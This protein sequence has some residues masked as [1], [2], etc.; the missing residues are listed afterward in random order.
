[1]Q[2]SILIAF[3]ILLVVALAVRFAGTAKILNIVEY[4]KV[5]DP[6]ALHTW[7][8]N[9][10]LVLSLIVGLLGAASLQFPTYGALFVI[11]FIC[12]VFVTVF[13]LMI[14]SGK[15]QEPVV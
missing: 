11:T 14:G 2:I 8:G 6:V 1:M 15:F 7:A 4:T 9:R 12:A 3:P 10:L 5:K 13:W